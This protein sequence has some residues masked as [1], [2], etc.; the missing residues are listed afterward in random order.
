MCR[1]IAR[2]SAIC[3]GCSTSIGTKETSNHPKRTDGRSHGI[4]PTGIG[5]SARR[6]LLLVCRSA[7][8]TREKKS[9]LIHMA[10]SLVKLIQMFSNTT[11]RSLLRFLVDEF[12]CVGKTT[13]L[14]ITLRP[15]VSALR[16]FHTNSSGYLS[17]E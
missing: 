17:G 4:V 1:L 12:S 16:C 14:E 2:L 11:S 9:N 13:A 7:S 10:S 15:T 8:V 3:G 5:L 6:R